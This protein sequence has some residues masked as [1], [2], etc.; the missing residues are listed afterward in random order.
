M[1]EIYKKKPVSVAVLA[2]DG[3]NFDEIKKFAGDMAFMDDGDLFI[4]TL[5]DTDTSSHAASVG[6][7]IVRGVKGEFYPVKPDVFMRTYEPCS[8]S[9]VEAYWHKRFEEAADS[10]L[11]HVHDTVSEGKD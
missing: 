3:R 7:L 1:I 5:E 8:E 10:G 2:W 4:H 9:E 11:I 6:D